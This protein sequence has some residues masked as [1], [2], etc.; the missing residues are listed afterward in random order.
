M[1]WLLVLKL[2]FIRMN[3]HL[4]TYARTYIRSYRCVHRWSDICYDYSPKWKAMIKRIKSGFLVVCKSWFEIKSMK[5]SQ[6]IYLYYWVNPCNQM[7]PHQWQS[8]STYPATQGPALGKAVTLPGTPCIHSQRLD[9]PQSV[10]WHPASWWGEQR[11]PLSDVLWCG[12]GGHAGTSHS[13]RA[14]LREVPPVQPTYR[15]QS[16]CKYVH[17]HMYV[18][19]S[20]VYP[21]IATSNNINH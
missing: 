17:A 14:L 6:S 9:G 21:T 20:Y 4:H 15:E 1:T 5:D 13:E 10:R 7:L 8:C 11:S 3:M 12:W 16:T 19:Y 18:W 2:E